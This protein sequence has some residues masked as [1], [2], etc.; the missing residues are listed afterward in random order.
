MQCTTELKKK[1]LLVLDAA[2]C[3]RIATA[4]RR[5]VYNGSMA[6]A[7]QTRSLRPCPC[8]CACMLRCA[9]VQAAPRRSTCHTA[10]KSSSYSSSLRY[11]SYVYRCM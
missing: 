7:Q 3:G 1:T 2:Y 10:N 6:S 9:A 5:Y 8:T 11:A 4:Y